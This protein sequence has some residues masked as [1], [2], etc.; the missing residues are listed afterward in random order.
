VSE[1]LAVALIGLGGAVLGALLVALI[2]PIW[3]KRIGPQ[4]KLIVTVRVAP[5]TVPQYLREA[6]E[7]Y[8]SLRWSEKSNIRPSVED[9]KKLRNIAQSSAHFTVDILNNSNKSIDGIV[10][11]LKNHPEFVADLIV[12]KSVT[13]MFGSVLDIGALKPKSECKVALWA[14]QWVSDNYPPDRD[15]IS[16]TAKEYDS[17][18]I[19]Y[20][21]PEYISKRYLMLN[22]TFLY[23]LYGL[24]FP[25]GGLGVAVAVV[26][27]I[28]LFG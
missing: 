28:R 10:L 5:L 8:A 1:A 23:P 6:V 14:T 12:G 27:L 11:H 13:T 7:S 26:G 3:T 20:P 15:I 16:V 18:V 25:V 2:Q 17:I 21:Y 4:S 19:D 9:I 22:R 24:L